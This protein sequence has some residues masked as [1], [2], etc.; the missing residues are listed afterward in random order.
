M[1]KGYKNAQMREGNEFNAW[2][3]LFLVNELNELQ[4][5]KLIS[6]ESNF[7]I[8][9][10]LM[11]GFGLKYLATQDPDFVFTDKNSAENYVLFFFVTVC[12]FYASGILQYGFR[13][14]TKPCN[15]LKVVEF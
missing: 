8:Y 2:R 9:G 10:L 14:L 4:T 5:A 15:S 6:T 3:H 7:L 13:Y 11:E 12:V 1:E